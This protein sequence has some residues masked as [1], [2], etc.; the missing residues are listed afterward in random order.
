MFKSLYTTHKTILMASPNVNSNSYVSTF[1]VQVLYYAAWVTCAI[2]CSG[3]V[4]SGN[5]Y[6]VYALAVHTYSVHQLIQTNTDN[7]YAGRR[8]SFTFFMDHILAQFYVWSLFVRFYLI[9]RQSYNFKDKILEVSIW[10]K[11]LSLFELL[12]C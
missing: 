9:Q 3:T 4:S 8:F 11:Y 12:K 5:S 10:F 6:K 7:L 2:L 1:S